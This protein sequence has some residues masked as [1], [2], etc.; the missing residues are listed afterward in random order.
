MLERYKQEN[1]KSA[2]ET[3]SFMFLTNLILKVRILATYIIKNMDFILFVYLPGGNL[4]AAFY[5]GSLCRQGY[6]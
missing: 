2:S 4:I 3:A 1:L 5:E 6:D